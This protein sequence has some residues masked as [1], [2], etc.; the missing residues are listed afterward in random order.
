MPLPNGVYRLSDASADRMLSLAGVRPGT[1]AG[2]QLVMLTEEEGTA[3]G[4]NWRV[5]YDPPHDA[6]SMQHTTSGMYVSFEGSVIE[7][8]H[9]GAHPKP[10]F[11][12]L[13]PSG[14]GVYKI[15]LSG[16]WFKVDMSPCMMYPPMVSHYKVIVKRD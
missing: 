1:G 9:L 8:A 15:H 7:N 5:Q 2:T 10:K 11:F 16:T 4:F 14:P 3:E 12:E 6:Y 13:Q